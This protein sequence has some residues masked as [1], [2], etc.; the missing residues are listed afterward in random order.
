MQTR[1]LAI[2]VAGVM[3]TK[4][5]THALKVG[6]TVKWMNSRDQWF[7]ER[8]AFGFLFSIFFVV[9]EGFNSKMNT[10]C[11]SWTLN[12]GLSEGDWG[13]LLIVFLR[14]FI[15]IIIIIVSFIVFKFR[16]E[17]RILRGYNKVFLSKV[18][19]TELWNQKHQCWY[20]SINSPPLCRPPPPPSSFSCSCNGCHS[21]L[22]VSILAFILL[23]HQLFAC[24]PSM[25][26]HESSLWCPFL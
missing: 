26:I 5:L 20:T 16:V 3:E 19:S 15:I 4:P 6:F 22:S 23:S 21:R 12:P 24:P 7:S 17:L 10:E 2:W 1:N 8:Q 25:Y 18:S 11:S 14:V 9:V 13:S